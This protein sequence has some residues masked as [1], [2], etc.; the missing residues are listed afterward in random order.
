MKD[1]QIAGTVGKN[2][3]IE[4]VRVKLTEQLAQTYDIY[5]RVNVEG[6]GWLDWTVNGGDAGSTGLDLA[7]RG[8]EIKICAKDGEEH[9][10]VGTRA[11][12]TSDNF[13][14]IVYQAHVQKIGWEK[15]SSRW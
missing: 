6:K 9:P 5:Y 3:Q 11:L 2:K 1:G 4:A 15:T 7:V 8:I 10:E 13:G 12:V 14:N